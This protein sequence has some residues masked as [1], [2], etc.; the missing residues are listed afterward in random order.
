MLHMEYYKG[1]RLVTKLVA[2][3]FC[4]CCCRN[5]TTEDTPRTCWAKPFYTVTKIEPVFF[6]F[7]EQELSSFPASGVTHRAE[8]G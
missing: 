5:Y 6:F 4:A 3:V 8:L 2:H 7:L 1:Q